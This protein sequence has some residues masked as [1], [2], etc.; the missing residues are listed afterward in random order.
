M[1]QDRNITPASIKVNNEDLE[2][3]SLLI[4]LECHVRNEFEIWGNQPHRN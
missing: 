3:N 1:S 4:R 2:V